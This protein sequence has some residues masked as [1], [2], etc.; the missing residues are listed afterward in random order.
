LFCWPSRFPRSASEVILR[1]LSR[2]RFVELDSP[3]FMLQ[4]KPAE[5]AAQIHR[6]LREVV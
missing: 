3:H 2:T 6:L 4:A 5:S 1:A